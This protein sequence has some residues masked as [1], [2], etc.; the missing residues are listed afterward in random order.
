M[1][2]QEAGN[3]PEIK[4]HHRLDIALEHGSV[5]VADIAK[6]IGY[7]VTQTSNYLHGRQYPRSGTIAAWA[8]RCGV[9]REWL[10]HGAV[11]TSP[12]GDGSHAGDTTM[13]RHLRAVSDLP[14]LTPESAEERAA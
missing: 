8:L 4:L 13:G 1:S 11:P 3:I 9:D 12:D 14:V 7:S 5:S 6:S 10:E 2:Q